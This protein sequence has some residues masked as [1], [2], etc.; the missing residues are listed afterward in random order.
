MS[1]SQLPELGQACMEPLGRFCSGPWLD[2][3][4]LARRPPILCEILGAWRVLGLREPVM[5]VLWSSTWIAAG[6]FALWACS[7]GT[8]PVPST[9][10]TAAGAASAKTQEPSVALR[11]LVPPGK[12]ESTA[13]GIVSPVG[14]DGETRRYA[15]TLVDSA[16]KRVYARAL[17]T[18]IHEAPGRSAPRLGYLRVGGSAPIAGPSVAASECAQGWQPIKPKGYVCMNEHATFDATDPAVDLSREHPPDFSRKLPY[19]YGTVRN[20]GPIY[21]ALPERAELTETEPGFEGRMAEWLTASGEVGSSYAPEVWLGPEQVAVEAAAVW[22]QGLS[23]D[24]PELL[25]GGR[26]APGLSG[27]QHERSPIVLAPMRQRVGFSFLSTFLWQGRRY[28]LTPEMEI[29]PTDRLRPIRGSELHGYQIGKDVQFPFALVRTPGAKFRS[30]KDAPYRA[31]LPLTGKQAFYDKVLHYETTDG[32][33]VSDRV[34][35]RLDPAKNMPGWGKNGEKWIDISVSKQTLMLYE[36]ELPVYATLVSTGEAGLSDH[37]TSTATKR[38]IFRIHTKHISATMSSEELGEEF[39][40]RDVP[41][42]MYFDKEGYALHGAY[43]HDRFG[44]PKSHGCIN[45]APEDA[46]RIFHWTEPAVPPGWH[47]ALLPLKG[48]VVFVHP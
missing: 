31:A 44:I 34:A 16:P 1:I 20:P 23:Q 21:G 25:T 8:E 39:E 30:G 10:Q 22:Q 32:D 18:W 29:L 13:D 2:K 28:G 11:D 17:R 24:V 6:T 42:V 45:L 4:R 19:I 3:A 36:G 40:L 14:L 7:R 48:T 41:Y 35:S 5:R 38:G 43:W 46:R 26:P 15:V 37:E 47:G 12:A 27:K 33:W 9:T